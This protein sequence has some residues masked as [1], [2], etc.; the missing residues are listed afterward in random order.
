MRLSH[1]SQ[2]IGTWDWFCFINTD[3]TSALI[4]KIMINVLM[5]TYRNSQHL[6]KFRERLKKSKV[7]WTLRLNMF[8]L[9]NLTTFRIICCFCSLAP[10]RP[11]FWTPVNGKLHD[12]QVVARELNPSSYDIFLLVL[13]AVLKNLHVC[14]TVSSNFLVFILKHRLPALLEINFSCT[15]QQFHK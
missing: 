3:T 8:P 2:C 4:L 13:L 11:R 6:D 10:L 15:D 14:S 1:R 9:T 5:V 12:L 7:T